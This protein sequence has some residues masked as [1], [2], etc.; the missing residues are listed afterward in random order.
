MMIRHNIKPYRSNSFIRM[1]AVPPCLLLLLVLGFA[2]TPANASQPNLPPAS[3]YT[4]I[5]AAP[6]GGFWVQLHTPGNVTEYRPLAIDGAPE[7][8]S[9]NEPGSIVAA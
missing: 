6:G 7:Y 3:N 4:S 8:E 1:L 5:A 2:T 9:V